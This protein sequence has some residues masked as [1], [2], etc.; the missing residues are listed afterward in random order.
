MDISVQADLMIITENIPLLQ[1]SKVKIQFCIY[2]P[3]DFW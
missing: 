2:K 1:L 3:A